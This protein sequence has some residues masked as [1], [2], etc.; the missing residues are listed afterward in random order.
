MAII[1]VSVPV[2]FGV[3][4]PGGSAALA[5]GAAV[6]QAFTA[7]VIVVLTL[8]LAA[9][10]EAAQEAASTQAD[11]ASR[12]LEQAREQLHFYENAD[13]LARRDKHLLETPPLRTC[14]VQYSADAAGQ[15][16]LQLT[17]HNEG[18]TPALNVKLEVRGANGP[19]GDPSPNSSTALI[20]ALSPGASGHVRIGL[21]E[22]TN[23]SWRMEQNPYGDDAPLN[24]RGA[25]TY[26]WLV[27]ELTFTGVLGQF[28]RQEYRLLVATADEPRWY[29]R[30]LS[31]R[32]ALADV[33]PLEVTFPIETPRGAVNGP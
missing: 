32:P 26:P 14:F 12:A 7:A 16:T 33:E 11:V 6:V 28:V 19:M 21:H 9:A 22:F 4:V 25:F 15:L 5:G 18:R 27:V 17:I 2:A 24:P 31:I 20:E 1:A 30:S 3:L 8:R 23:M 29:H 10:T 13:R